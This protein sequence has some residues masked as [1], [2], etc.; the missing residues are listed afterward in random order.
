[1]KEI[2]ELIEQYGLTLILLLGSLYALYRFF[3]FSIYEV[4]G[5]F[6]KYHE[7]NAKDMQYIKSKIDII[8]EFIK[9]KKK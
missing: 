7:N 8:L 1:M 2:L 5:Q 3:I 9:E 6:S 4:K